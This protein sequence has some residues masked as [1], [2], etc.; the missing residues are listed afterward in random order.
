MFFI[1]TD[2]DVQ[3]QMFVYQTECPVFEKKQLPYKQFYKISR[4]SQSSVRDD[5]FFGA[6]H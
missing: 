6:C 3:L 2:C 1:T 5:S 4:F